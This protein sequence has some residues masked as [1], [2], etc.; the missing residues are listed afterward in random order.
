MLKHGQRF[1]TDI[2][3]LPK[4]KSESELRKL[5]DDINRNYSWIESG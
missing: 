1:I 2:F 3:S 4:L 5:L